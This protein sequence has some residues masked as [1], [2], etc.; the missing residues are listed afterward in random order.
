MAFETFDFPLRYGK[1]SN[2]NFH[3]AQK[4]A[5]NTGFGPDCVEFRVRPE[6]I[7]PHPQDS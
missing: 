5:P 6:K 3:E 2:G 1:S 4:K 7:S